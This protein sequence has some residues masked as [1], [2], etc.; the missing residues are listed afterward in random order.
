M[1]TS[2]LCEVHRSLG[3]DFAPCGDCLVAAHYGDVNNEYGSAV[4][5]CVVVDL[6]PWGKLGV[7]GAGRHALLDRCLTRD[8]RRLEVGQG[9]HA[10]ALNHRGRLVA[11]AHVYA[12]D[13]LHLL[14]T[15]PHAAQ[16]LAR[17]LEAAAGA[18]SQ[19]ALRDLRRAWGLV[20]LHGPDS[21]G[22]LDT[23]GI[24]AP[25]EG[26]IA[27][28]SLA[29]HRLLVAGRR[30]TA[31]PGFDVFAT[32][33]ALLDCWNS[34]VECGVRPAGLMAL[35]VLRIE[36]GIPWYGLDADARVAPWEI[37]LDALISEAKRGYVGQEAVARARERG[38]P[39]RRL[40]GLTLSASQPPRP[41]TGVYRDSRLVGRVTSAAFSP[42]LGH[43]VAL[44]LLRRGHTD[45]G[46]RVQVSVD[47]GTAEGVVTLLPFTACPLPPERAR[48]TG[49]TA[50]K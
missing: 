6:S 41:G 18:S 32:A 44:A 42:A 16:P 39:A 12:L 26:M 21:P 36:A 5:S 47:T 8:I 22:V 29:G 45:P 2:P 37:G 30:R 40:R 33:G 14:E 48:Q 10:A 50:G 19:V 9:V 11:D 1:Y 3:A 34:I 23:L 27:S 35:Q 38:E 4:Q 13:G 28:A 43:P 24:G 46:T 17:A 20:S 15:V 31:F 49:H 25:P 7:A